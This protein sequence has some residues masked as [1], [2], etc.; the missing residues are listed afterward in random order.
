MRR[1]AIPVDSARCACLDALRLAGVPDAVSA[2]VIDSLIWAD[3]RGV[4]SHGVRNLPVYLRRVEQG[5]LDSSA[6][7]ETVLERGA[8]AVMNGRNGFG[9]VA[10]ADA[11]RVALR[12][13]E[14]HGA[15][16]VW[17]SDT[18]HVGA[19]GY[20]TSLAA[21]EGRVA[22]MASNTNPTVAPYGGTD[23]RLGTNPLSFSFPGV[24]FPIVV[25]L[26][27][28]AVAKGKIYEMAG[29][30][31]S[32]PEG[33][34]LDSRGVP[35]TSAEEAIRGVLLPMGGPKGYS[36]A[37]AVEMLAGTLTGCPGRTLTSLHNEPR[38]PQ[39]VGF[40]L[41]VADTTHVVSRDVYLDR[42]AEFVSYVRSSR[43]ADRVDEV[44][45]PGEFEARLQA[46]R[47]DSGIQIAEA[48]WAAICSLAGLARTCPA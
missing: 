1:I 20:Y 38:K 39:R 24:E 29:R 18:N 41:M 10:G 30:G 33:W 13:C 23:P 32:I 7:P 14:E 11:V 27:T 3:L 12:L 44:L 34:S 31:E 28:S 48:D 4:S 21:E 5:G 35:T 47:G 25:D 42:L 15:G 37:I 43:R 9:Q 22:F 6:C 36:L 45:L 2:V 8:V 26:A 19:L 16:L 40:F 46:G 17:V